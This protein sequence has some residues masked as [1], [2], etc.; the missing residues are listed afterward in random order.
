MISVGVV[1]EQILKVSMMISQ[2]MLRGHWFVTGAHADIVSSI[3]DNIIQVWSLMGLSAIEIL[4]ANLDL[5]FFKDIHR[6]NIPRN[7]P[8]SQDN[9]ALLR[10]SRDFL[11]SNF[12]KIIQR[13]NDVQPWPAD[14]CT[15]QSIYLSLL[16]AMGI[17]TSALQFT[18]ADIHIDDTT[19]TQ[20]YCLIDGLADVTMFLMQF[21]HKNDIKAVFTPLVCAN[22]S[23]F[24]DSGLIVGLTKTNKRKMDPPLLE[25]FSPYK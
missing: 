9:D 13:A 7:S 20:K 23:T 18:S 14:Q 24:C 10:L 11:S 15:D 12:A 3:F 4:N 19:E 6:K 5:V 22:R 21:C 16:S 8:F 17:A 2:L 1:Q 25:L